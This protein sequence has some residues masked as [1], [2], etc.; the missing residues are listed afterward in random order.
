MQQVKIYIETDSSSPKATEKHYGYVLEVMVSGQ[1]VTREGFGKITG[2][3]HQ[4]VLTAL[5]KALDRF[6]QSCEVCICTEDDFVLNM[7]ERN[8]AIWAGNE[9]LTSKRKPVARI[10]ELDRATDTIMVKETLEEI[11]MDIKEHTAMTFIPRG[12]ADVPSL[13][14]VWM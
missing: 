13:V 5:A 2:T 8:L 3:Y 14:G 9:F 10:Y 12:T 1:A 6:N 4:T 11:E 7:L